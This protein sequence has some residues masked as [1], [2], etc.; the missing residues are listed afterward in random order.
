MAHADQQL[1]HD[2]RELIVGMYRQMQQQISNDE[3][4]SVAAQ[5][6]MY[7]LTLKEECLPSELCAQLNTSS[8]YISQ[9]FNHLEALNY[10][11]RKPSTTDGRKTWVSLTEQGRQKVLESRRQREEWLVERMANRLSVADKVIV[12]KA[13]VL[14]SRLL[15]T[16]DENNA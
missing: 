7:Q 16:P 12:E 3:H 1:A 15:N 9:V 11:T 8:Q 13:L 4:L 14:L 5:N 6:V 2:L 10:I